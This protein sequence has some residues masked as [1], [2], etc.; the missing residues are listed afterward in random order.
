[1]SANEPSGDGLVELVEMARKEMVGVIDDGQLVFTG[2][3][4]DEFGNFGLGA[5]L[6]VGAMDEEF[7]LRTTP[8]VCEIGV[9]DGNAEANQIGDMR[10]G[11]TD[12]KANPTP[13]TETGEKQGDIRKL[14][15]KRIDGGLDVALLALAAV[16]RSGAESRTAKIEPQDRNTEGIQGFGGLIDNLVVEG[17]AVQGV[18]VANHSREQGGG[19]ARWGPEDS[20][21]TANRTLQKEIA[22]IVGNAHKRPGKGYLKGAGRRKVIGKRSSFTSGEKRSN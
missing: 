18:W 10:I 2:Q 5:M 16:I 11:T 15:G 17:A 12:A 9:V 14:S 21:Q 3:C 4:S 13:K 6:I 22:G 20:L 1:M 8:Q 7:G 19:R